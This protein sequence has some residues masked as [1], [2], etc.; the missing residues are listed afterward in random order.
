VESG[1][2]G[3]YSCADETDAAGKALFVFQGQ[4]GL[5]ALKDLETKLFI[6]QFEAVN[7]QGG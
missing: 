2:A 5:A 7:Q 1:A 6:Q 3:F 4:A